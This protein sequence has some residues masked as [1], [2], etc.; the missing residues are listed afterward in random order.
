MSGDSVRLGD[1][2]SGYLS[3]PEKVVT[4]A[5]APGQRMVLSAEWLSNLAHT[6]GL[7]WHPISEYDRAIVYQPGKTVSPQDILAAVKSALVEKGL[8]T[9]SALMPVASVGSVTVA[10]ASATDIGVRE[11]F[12]DAATPRRLSCPCAAPFMQPSPCRC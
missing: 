12:Y 9:N 6:Y 4:R 10:S 7:A 8:D 2:F 1:I 3:R 11:A 5:P